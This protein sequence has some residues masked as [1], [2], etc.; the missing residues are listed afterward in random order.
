MVSIPCR[1][2]ICIN[3][4]VLFHWIIS[5]IVLSCFPFSWFSEV[6]LRSFSSIFSMGKV[7]RI[8]LNMWAQSCSN[9]MALAPLIWRFREF[10]QNWKGN[11]GIWE[12]PLLRTCSLYWDDPCVQVSSNLAPHSSR[13]SFGRKG[14]SFSQALFITGLIWCQYQTPVPF[15]QTTVLFTGLVQSVSRQVRSCFFSSTFVHCFERNLLTISPID[16][17]ILLLAS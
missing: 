11:L 12:K 16:P 14:L 5:Y 2:L 15:Y 8:R 7:A 9:S 13:S 4:F 10:I 1:L 6:F 17:I 3:I